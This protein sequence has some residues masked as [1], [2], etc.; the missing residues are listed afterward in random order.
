M[1]TQNNWGLHGKQIQEK[2][3]V[4]NY[5]AYQAYKKMYATIRLLHCSIVECVISVNPFCGYQ[6]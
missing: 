4:V 1:N 6:S 5:M 2:T 3:H